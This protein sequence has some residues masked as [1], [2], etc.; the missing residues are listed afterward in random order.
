MT[1]YRPLFILIVYPPGRD[2]RSTAD[3]DHISDRSKA[4][5]GIRYATDADH[6]YN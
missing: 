1:V 4:D 3:V 2:I 6:I 5:V